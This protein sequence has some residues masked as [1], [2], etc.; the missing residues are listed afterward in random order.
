MRSVVIATGARMAFAAAVWCGAVLCAQAQATPGILATY[1]LRW[2]QPPS[3]WPSGLYTLHVS[4]TESTF[5]N[6]EEYAS[7]STVQSGKTIMV[8]RKSTP[9]VDRRMI[10]SNSTK[11]TIISKY[12]GERKLILTDSLAMLPWEISD[13]TKRCIGDA[14]C[15]RATVDYGG[16]AYE[17][18][19]LPSLP[20][21]FGVHRLHGLPG[22]MAELYSAD[23]LISFR[24]TKPPERLAYEPIAYQSGTPGTD[25]DV[26]EAIIRFLLDVEARGDGIDRPTNRDPDPDSDFEIGRWTQIRDYKLAEV[27]AGRR[28]LS[29]NDGL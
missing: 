10:V 24:L 7:P 22:L 6:L 12:A 1:E 27:R 11:G 15:R 19:F 8:V 29:A 28:V 20:T 21:H 2:A 3:F 16:R 18:W 5:R 9:D 23:S 14:I 17:A 25:A 26:R 13:S 4:D